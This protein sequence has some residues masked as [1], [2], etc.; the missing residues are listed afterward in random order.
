MWEY[1]RAPSEWLIVLQLTAGT[2]YKVDASSL[3]RTFAVSNSMPSSM[4]KK[5]AT[6]FVQFAKKTGRASHLCLFYLYLFGYFF[7]IFSLLISIILFKMI[8]KIMSIA[9]RRCSCT[10]VIFTKK[11]IIK[12]SLYAENNLLK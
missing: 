9:A 3:T 12:I 1:T 10:I 8:Y 2:S 4:W 6:L 5:T 7:F 11:Y